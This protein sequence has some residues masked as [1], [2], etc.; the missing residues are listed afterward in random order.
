M[1]EEVTQ[2]SIAIVIRA[3]T[4]TA[5]VLRKAM[6]AY[7]NH[8]KNKAIKPKEPKHGKISV[9]KLLA[10]D[11][12]ATSMEIKESNIKAFERV[13]KKYNVDFAVKKDKT[14][15][16][17]KYVVFFKGRD[18]DVI[19]MAF[20]E[21]VHGNEQKSKGRKSLRKRLNRYKELENKNKNKERT[22]EKKKDR[23]KS[24]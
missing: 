12:G 22:R 15:D 18:A 23:G 11:Q 2:K 3:T 5:D 8:L 17:P 13:A 9:R 21:F 16:L 6:V 1:Q 14:E 19:A 7:L 4:L 20:K 10:K 24:R